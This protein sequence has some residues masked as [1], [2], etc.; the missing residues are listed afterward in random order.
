MSQAREAGG[1]LTSA[2]FTAWCER[3]QWPLYSFLCGI[4]RDDEQAR[5]LAQET[6]LRAWRVAQTGQPPFGAA[7]AEADMRRWLFHVAYTRAVSSLRRHRIIQWQPLDPP[8]VASSAHAPAVP[9]EDTVAEQQALRDALAAL[10]PA[11]AAC[12]LLVVV[13]G[14]T[15]AETAQ[16]VGGTAQAVAK[17]FARAKQR[18]RAVYLAQNAEMTEGSHR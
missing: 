18:L 17:R 13:Q 6:L 12:L 14:F 8:D 2:E 11:D 15:A 10:A 9:F 5:D 7:R 1:R 16:I 3:C 4:I